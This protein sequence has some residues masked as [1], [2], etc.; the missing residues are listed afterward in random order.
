MLD[1]IESIVRDNFDY[2]VGVGSYDFVI[3]VG[4]H[5]IKVLVDFVRVRLVIYDLSWV[6][7]LEF[8]EEFERVFLYYLR[9]VIKELGYYD[10]LV[11][12]KDEFGDFFDYAD[13]S[14]SF[15]DGIY[16]LDLLSSSSIVIRIVGDRLRV[17]YS[18]KVVSGEISSGFELVREGL[19]EVGILK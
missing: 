7:P 18:G 2:S 11:S 3:K 4:A 12:I 14:I 5:S 10:T 8:G 6:I 19:R 15:G 16:R 17:D 13:F 1:Y 9:R